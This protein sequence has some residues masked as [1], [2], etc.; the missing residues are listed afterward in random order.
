MKRLAV[1]PAR[2]TTHEMPGRN[3]V[4]LGGKPLIEY[5]ITAA[6]KAGLFNRIIVASEWADVISHAHFCGVEG[7]EVFPSVI[8]EPISAVV[9]TVWRRLG[10]PFGEICVLTP[11]YP[12]RTAQDVEKCLHELK[13]NSGSHSAM[14]VVRDSIAFVTAVYRTKN[15]YWHE[16]TPRGISSGKDRFCRHKGGGIFWVTEEYFRAKRQIES[17]KGSIYEIERVNG[18]E[19]RSFQDFWAAE[20]IINGYRQAGG[21]HYAKANL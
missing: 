14:S 19:V 11:S 21:V 1:I 4:K 16:N 15:K 13:V 3:M 5:T 2:Y 9:E 18:L 8:Q 12:F 6:K 20:G 10:E 17:D 7:L